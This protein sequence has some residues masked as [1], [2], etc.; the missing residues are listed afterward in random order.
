MGGE[1]EKRTAS[2]AI[3]STGTTNSYSDVKMYMRDYLAAV[4]VS[5]PAV[6]V[7]AC[8]VGED[9]CCCTF[10]YSIWIM[11]LLSER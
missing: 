9:I 10:L 4:S 11:C 8:H 1:K 7:A 5:V 3:P 6:L 2:A